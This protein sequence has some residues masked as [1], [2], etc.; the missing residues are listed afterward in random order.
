MALKS[1]PPVDRDIFDLVGNTPLVPLRRVGAHVRPVQL[2]AKAEWFNPSGSIKD[3]PARQIILTAEAEGRLTRERILLD[4][5]SGNMGIAYA[6]LCAARGYRTK[7]VI[8]SNASPERIKI[9]RAYGAE[10]VFTDA[11]E[12][13]DGAIRV[14]R[15]IAASDPKLYF[16][17]DQYSNPSNWQA[18]YATTGVEVWEQTQGRITHWVTGLGTSGTF[19]GAG[20]RLLEFAPSIQ[21]VTVQPDSPLHGVEGWKHYATAMVPAI[22]DASVATAQVE[23]TTEAAY[24]MV[25]RLARE[26]GLFVGVSA[27]AAAVGALHVA[28]KLS[29][30]V[31]VTVFPD[32]GFK[33]LSERFWEED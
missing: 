9:L 3:R 15:E 26:E 1:Q 17:A 12:G 25:K 13:A 7:L 32:A 5:T 24:A 28:E 4:A 11:L 27:A 18:H 33:Y 6:M 16:Y 23:V 21:R 20:R 30:G 29:E 2:Y 31:V 22:Y 14:A 19:V 8:P 10:L